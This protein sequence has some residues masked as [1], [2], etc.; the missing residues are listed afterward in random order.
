MGLLL[1]RVAL[2]L[3]LGVASLGAAH[4]ETFYLGASGGVSLWNVDCVGATNCD[5][6]SNAFRG[7]VGYN[8]LGA[9]RPVKVGIE[10]F[11]QDFGKITGSFSTTPGVSALS[12]KASGYG[13]ALTSS[14]RF[15]PTSRFGYFARIG[16]ANVEAT[17]T[18]TTFG[19]STSTKKDSVRAVLGAGVSFHVTPNLL[20]R[21]EFDVG[22]AKWPDGQ[23]SGIASV[24]GGIAV[25][26]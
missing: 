15:T 24:M 26:F 12:V 4:A 1:E 2:S 10:A 17:M 6:S 7:F 11:Y 14:G 19:R 16:A 9:G 25:H 13:L 5:D 20:L 21:A 18:G 8:F 23:T 22:S 3:A